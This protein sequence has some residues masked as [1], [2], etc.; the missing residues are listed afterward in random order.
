[1][2]TG[3]MALGMVAG[4]AATGLPDA[5]GT[6]R[7]LALG[8]SYTIGEGV[9]EDGRWPLQLARAL[10]AEGIPLADPRIIA[11]TGWTTDE[12]SA[13]IDAA[14]PG[15]VEAASVG[16]ASA[17]SS[18]K[19][20][21]SRDFHRRHEVKSSR[22]KPLPQAVLAA[23]AT[24]AAPQ[25]QPQPQPRNYDLVSLLIGVNNQYRGRDVDGYR[26]EFAALLER[27]IG[28]AGGNPG[29]VLVLSIPDWGVTRFGR[30]SGRDTDAIARELDAYNAAARAL[31]E[32][33]GVAFV[34]I[35]TASRAHGA[36]AAMLADDG[37][38]PS[39]RAYADWTRLALPVARRLLGPR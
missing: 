11:A 22:L 6:L 24:P 32:A 7:Y 13:A 34:D 14:D 39:A 4:C 21:G 16:A 3:L 28:F 27:A 26:T 29:R 38:H 1:M 23:E 31:C 8:D 19:S 10:R 35:T 20:D 36:Q 25:P 33:R 18:C 17:A 5:A 9:A 15:A 37:L 30:E 2:A 12:L